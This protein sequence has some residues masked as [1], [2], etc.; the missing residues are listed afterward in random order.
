M[1]W[2]QYAGAARK[3]GPNPFYRVLEPS[4]PTPGHVLE[5]G[6]GVGRASNGGWSA[7]GA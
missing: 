1:A 6:F 2:E 3:L 4:L 7:D 5:L